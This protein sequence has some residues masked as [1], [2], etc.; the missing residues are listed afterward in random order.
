MQPCS[1][2][3]RE[4]SQGIIPGRGEKVKLTRGRCQAATQLQQR[5]GHPCRELWSY[6]GPSDFP[7]DGIRGQDFTCSCWP[8]SGWGYPE[9]NLTLGEVTVFI[10]GNS[11][12]G[13]MAEGIPSSWGVSYSVVTGAWVLHQ[14][15]YNGGRHKLA[16]GQREGTKREKDEQ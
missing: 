7:W 1:K 13:L 3:V 8:I 2:T 14:S 12:R 16:C 6:S 15:A 4:C 10:G 11:Q 5:L 9:K